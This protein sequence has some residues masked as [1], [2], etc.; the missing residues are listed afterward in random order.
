MELISADTLLDGGTTCLTVLDGSENIHITIDYS[1][2][3]DGRLR[4][5]YTGK[6]PFSQE[7]QL[8]INSKEEKEFVTWLKSELITNYGEGQI[9]GYIEGKINGFVEGKWL[10][11]LNFLRLVAKERDYV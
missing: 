9:R 4:H 5:I 1:L 8:E 7:N 10:F 3:L 6:T 2:P 11:A